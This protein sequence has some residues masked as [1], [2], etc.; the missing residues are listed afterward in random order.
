M[1]LKSVCIRSLC[2]VMLSALLCGTLSSCGGSKKS[3]HSYKLTPETTAVKGDLSDYYEVVDKEYTT[4]NNYR[5]MMDDWHTIVAIEIKRTD[6]EFDF[7]SESTLPMLKE[8][9]GLTGNAGFGIEIID[10]NGN[11]IAKSAATDGGIHGMYNDDDMKE[12]LKLKPG[13]TA[14][15]RWEINFA[16]DDKPVKFRLTSAYE[17]S[18]YDGGNTEASASSSS[19]NNWD[20]TLDSYE[21]YVDQYIVVYKKVQSGDMS[22]MAEMGSMLEKAEDLQKKLDG[23]ES[24]LTAAQASRLAKIN[25]KLMSAM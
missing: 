6:K 5:T 4:T 18:G 13:E 15:V 8:S 11:V 22:V 19:S 14:T 17:K 23:A 2:A 10:E 1:N 16:D 3:D 7:D 20:A 21:K 9:V 12:A 25:S 24:E